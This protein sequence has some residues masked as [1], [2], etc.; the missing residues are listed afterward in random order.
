MAD[1]TE[2]TGAAFLGLTLSCCRCHDHKYDPL[3]QADH[4]RL[5]A[6]FEPL[7]YADDLPLD[8]ADEQE[9]IRRHNAQLDAETKKIEQQRTELLSQAKKRLEEER[10]EKFSKSEQELLA[11]PAD[12]LEKDKRSRAEELRKRLVP[13]DKEIAAALSAEEKQHDKQFADDLEALKKK[14]R[15]FNCGLLATDNTGP[16]AITHILKQGDY[17]SELDAVTPGFISALDPNAAVISAGANRE[18][19]G[20]R[21]TLA[22]WIASPENPLTARVIVNRIW[23]MHFAEGLVATPNDFG[24]AGARP[25][26]PELLDWLAAEFVREGWS[27]KRLHRLIVTSAV[28]R[29]SSADSGSGSASKRL[30]ARQAMRRLSAEQLRD[31]VLAVAGQLTAKSD[32]P[33]VWPDLPPEVLQGNPAV[34]DDNA[35]HTKGWYPS[36]QAEQA[37]RSIFLV[38]KRGISVPFLETFDLPGNSTSCPR[39]NLST[40][41]PQAFSLLNSPLAVAAAKKLAERVDREAGANPR[42]QVTRLFALALQRAPADDELAACL[43]LL[44][45][46]NLV[47]LC[48]VCLNL[49]E[50]IYVD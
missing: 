40:V 36:P 2:T 24:L 12:K 50:F 41:A 43:R 15:K 33:P 14:H 3:S 32:G 44:R 39:R 6:F 19:T 25:S 13:S 27:L 10:R 9:A 16:V 26:H 22:N 28:Y 34:L 21:L 11:A 23:Q 48:R 38:Q 46:R 1:L 17:R 20:R 30:Y 42:A 7:R 5:R 49:N 35:E 45:S 18:T 31:A 8:L 37:A 4:Y 47:E 29:Q